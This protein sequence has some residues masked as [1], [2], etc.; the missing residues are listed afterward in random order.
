[1]YPYKS[2]LKSRPISLGTRDFKQASFLYETYRVSQGKPA[3]SHYQPKHKIVEP[4]RFNGVGF[5]I[6]MKFNPLLF[7]L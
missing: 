6:G 7:P 4:S 5:G 3:P 2:Q 1:M